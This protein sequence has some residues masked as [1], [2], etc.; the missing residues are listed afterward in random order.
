M[1]QIM[2][3]NSNHCGGCNQY[4]VDGQIRLSDYCELVVV[5]PKCGEQ[6][7]MIAITVDEV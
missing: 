7:H 3:P 1:I 4:L 2:M 6:T 5:C